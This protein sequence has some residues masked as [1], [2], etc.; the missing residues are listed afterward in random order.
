MQM[1]IG[2]FGN[3]YDSTFKSIIPF[4]NRIIRFEINVSMY[5]QRRLHS[6]FMISPIVMNLLEETEWCSTPRPLLFSLSIF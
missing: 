3:M 1:S 6:E 5:C 4:Q 2:K